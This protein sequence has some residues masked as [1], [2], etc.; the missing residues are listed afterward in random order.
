MADRLGGSSAHEDGVVA[1]SRGQARAHAS[2]VR[3]QDLGLEALA[4]LVESSRDG[5]A[6]L[7]EQLRV[8]YINPAGCEI[9]GY[10]LEQII[11]R[12]GLLMVPAE[13]HAEVRQSLLQRFR[14]GPRGVRTTILRADGQERDIEYTGLLCELDG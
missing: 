11:G 2:T 13:R 12:T 14:E 10:P 5:I 6:R 7:D 4:Q 3:P 1:S 8:I 9:V